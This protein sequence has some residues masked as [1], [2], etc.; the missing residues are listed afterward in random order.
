MAVERAGERGARGETAQPIRHGT[1]FGNVG[2]AATG[3]GVSRLAVEI[4]P[5]LFIRALILGLLSDLCAGINYTICLLNANVSSGTREAHRSNLP[6]VAWLL[7][8]EITIYP[9]LV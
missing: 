1:V 8:I 9:C 7:G 5:P 4:A 2:A 6:I 3:P